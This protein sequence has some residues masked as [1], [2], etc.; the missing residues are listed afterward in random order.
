M[1]MV[2]TQKLDNF[3]LDLITTRIKKKTLDLLSEKGNFVAHEPI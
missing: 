1:S 2:F 3:S